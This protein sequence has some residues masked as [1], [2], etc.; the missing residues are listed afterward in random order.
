MCLGLLPHG[1]ERA[2]RLNQYL[3]T[4]AQ[5]LDESQARERLGPLRSLLDKIELTDALTWTDV[6]LAGTGGRARVMDC[7]SITELLA[8]N[9]LHPVYEANL[10]A[11]AARLFLTEPLYATAGNS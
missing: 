11:K 7:S 2:R 1:D 4:P 3:S 8:T 10:P 5:T 6:K 9:A